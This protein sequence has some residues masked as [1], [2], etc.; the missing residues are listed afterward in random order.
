MPDFFSNLYR[1]APNSNATQ[2]IYQGPAIDRSGQT[3][4]RYAE[5]VGTL[6]AAGDR[7][8]IAGGFAEGERLH[9]FTNIRSGDGDTDNDLT[10]NLG[11]RIGTAANPATAFLSASAGAQAAAAIVLA[12]DAVLAA[13]GAADG[14]DLLFGVQAGEAEASQTWRF[15]VESFIP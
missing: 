5:F 13:Q 7:L 11:W 4:L 12:P 10:L 6:P 8:F 1:T 15:L 9:R 14:D 2:R 3:V